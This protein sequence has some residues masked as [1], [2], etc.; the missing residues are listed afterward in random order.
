MKKKNFLWNM[1]TIMMVAMLSVSLSSC[2]NDDDESSDS[3]VGTWRLTLLDDDG[4]WH[5]QYKFNSD[6]TLEVKDWVEREPNDYE[7][8]GKWSTNN[9]I[10]SLA[11]DEYDDF[12]DGNYTYVESYRY[13]LKGNQLII[14]DYEVAGPNV[15]EKIK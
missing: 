9:G 3:I 11:I 1:L 6:G 13:E 12:L 7:A 2:S 8:T 10:I 14:Y 15:F 5:C 4:I